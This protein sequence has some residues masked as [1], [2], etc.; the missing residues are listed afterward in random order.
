MADAR[1]RVLIDILSKFRKQ[2]TTAAAAGSRN[3]GKRIQG[4]TKMSKSWNIPLEEVDRNLSG[5]GISMTKSGRIASKTTG[6]FMKFNEGIA[7][8]RKK[9]VRFR[10]EFLS[11]MFGFMAMQKA[12]KGFWDNLMKTYEKATGAQGDFYKATNK[13]RAAWEFFKYSLIDALAQSD[14]FRTL[15]DWIFSMVNGINAFLARHPN[16]KEWLPMAVLFGVIVTTIGLMAAQAALFYFG[17][18]GLAAQAGVTTTIMLLGFLKIFGVLLLIIVAIYGI[19]EILGGIASKDL[20]RIG[21][22][23]LI[24][25][26]AIIGILKILGLVSLGFAGIAIIVIIVVAEIIAHWE[27]LKLYFSAFWKGLVS[28][29]MTAISKVLKAFGML[30]SLIPRFKGLGKTFLKTSDDFAKAGKKIAEEA[31]KD[32]ATGFKKFREEE[33]PFVGILKD[34][35]I[36]KRKSKETTDAMEKDI[37][38][39]STLTEGTKADPWAEFAAGTGGVPEVAGIV[40]NSFGEM[41][42][43][44]MEYYNQNKEA[45]GGITSDMEMFGG[46][47]QTS[48]ANITGVSKKYIP[49][50]IGLMT[51][52][53]DILAEA[54]KNVTD[55]EGVLVKKSLVPV[56]KNQFAPALELINNLVQ[57]E[58]DKFKELIELFDKLISK[59]TKLIERY[60]A[61]ARAKAKSGEGGGLFGAARRVIGLQ[62]GGYISQTGLFMLHKGETVTPANRNIYGGISVS[63]NVSTPVTD[64]DEL[65]NVI[66]ERIGE[67][68]VRRIL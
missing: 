56:M 16:L 14:L 11:L 59:I 35:G 64:A 27:S 4:L 8:G 13:L 63:V 36:L 25:G 40:T 44:I 29:A 41:N 57:V 42:N 32:W 1:F 48:L 38:S 22:G 60:E 45:F 53:K 20:P 2:G 17:L 61:L 9:L 3:L 34:M 30:F 68:L 47:M 46:N 7:R 58:I 5:M 51:N 18:V 67:E 24:A 15:V 10:M 28:S 33:D 43:K 54:K 12:L 52:W 50:N 31:T 23:V 66:S 26:S 62:K 19:S 49:E 39:L 21:K 65:A 6:Q 37:A 55:L